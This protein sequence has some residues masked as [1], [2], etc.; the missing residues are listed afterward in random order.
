MDGLNNRWEMKEE[1]I[2]EPKHRKV[3]I[4]QYGQ[5]REIDWRERKKIKNR[6][7]HVRLQQNRQ[8]LYPLSPRWREVKGRNASKAL[9]EIGLQNDP[10]LSSQIKL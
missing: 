8:Q 5:Y 6:N 10:N 4:A 7:S 3:E 1:R 2:Y 9:K